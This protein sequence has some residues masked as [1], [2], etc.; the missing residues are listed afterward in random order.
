MDVS[1]EQLSEF[2]QI[3]LHHSLQVNKEKHNIHLKNQKFLCR[4]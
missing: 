1:A 2:S 4:S 3:N